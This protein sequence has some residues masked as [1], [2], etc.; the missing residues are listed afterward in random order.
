MVPRALPDRWRVLLGALLVLLAA[1]LI[2]VHW[3]FSAPMLQMGGE[4]RTM[5]EQEQALRSEAAQRIPAQ[6]L[7][8]MAESRRLDNRKMKVALGFKLR[9][10]TVFEG[11]PLNRR[12]A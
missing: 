12:A 4:I 7:S 6:M 10:P 11:V 3:W 1:Y 2:L 9:Y 5:R 8:F